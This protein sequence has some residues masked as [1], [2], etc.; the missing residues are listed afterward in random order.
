ML[1]LSGS[2]CN[3]DL[4]PENVLEGL[5]KPVIYSISPAAVRCSGAGF[6]LRVGLTPKDAQYVLYLN[7]RKVGQINRG[8]RE[9]DPYGVDWMLSKELLGEF[10]ATSPNGAFLSVRITSINQNYDISG[11]FEKYCDY[12]SEPATLEIRKGETQFSEAKQLFPEW[13]HSSEPIIR[14][15]PQGNIY[16]AWREKLNGVYQTFFS[17][18]ADSGE[19]WS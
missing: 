8:D 5:H 7:E 13:T 15:D 9:Y 14:C 6:F 18:S 16:L 12:V 4:V 10:L 19:T 2:A 3:R 17:F 11:A 1:L